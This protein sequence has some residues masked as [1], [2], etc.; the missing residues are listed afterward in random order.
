[1]DQEITADW[2]SLFSQ[3]MDSTE[4]YFQHAKRTLETS[5]LK[6][7]AADV[8]ALAAVSASEFQSTCIGVAAQKVESGLQAI[9]SEL[10][11]RE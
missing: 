2:G 11:S 8:V 5:G 6:F 1:M 10:A 4:S 7:T 9:A 3:S